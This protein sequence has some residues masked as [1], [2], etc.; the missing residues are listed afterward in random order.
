M[1]PPN[2]IKLRWKKLKNEW[3]YAI[4]EK[5]TIVID[6]RLDDRTTAEIIIHEAAHCEFPY[7]EEEPVN[8]HGR[9]AADLLIRAGYTR[10]H[11]GEE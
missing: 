6:P 1:K 2:P 7:L 3:G 11:D 9:N 5:R 10:Q 8:N 4:P